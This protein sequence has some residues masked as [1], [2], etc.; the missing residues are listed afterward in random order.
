[1]RTA[2]RFRTVRHATGALRL[3]ALGLALTVAT[4]SLLAQPAAPTS[5]D[6]IYLDSV[7]RA[8]RYPIALRDGRLSGDGAR[9]LS[10]ATRNAQ[11]VVLGESH[12]VAEI[13]RY[14]AALFSSLR[15]SVGFQH[16][17]VEN[18]PVIGSMLSAPGVRGR[19]DASFALARRYPRALQFWDDEEIDAISRI[20]AL[21]AARTDPVWGLD[22]EWGALHVLE[23]L[24]VLAPTPAAR[25]V[26]SALAD[27]AR[28]LESSRP[29][30]VADLPRFIASADSASF[31]RLRRAFR[32]TPHSEAERLIT[33]LVVSNA[34]YRDNAGANAGLPTGYRANAVR[35]L[36]MKE[37]FMKQYRAAVRGGEPL[38]HV[39]VKIGSVHGG[40]WLSSNSTLALGDFLHEFAIANGRES[41][42]LVAW[43]V[44]EPG[45][46]WSITDDPAFR[47]LGR[48]G[49]TKES[50]IVDLRPLRDLW[51]AGRLRA[52]DREM[53]KWMFGYDA[54]LLIGG[55][56][57][58]TYERL[59]QAAVAAP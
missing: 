5:R 59:R 21:S 30:A 7:L 53:V 45:N 3:A 26:A 55:G 58:G 35:E 12:Y 29:F 47:A 50:V 28:L 32:P 4:P 14:A 25:A 24:A 11:F 51:Y 22:Q 10:E 13:P 52:L 31:E 8:H 6:T 56:T 36:Y 2:S 15:A 44:N 9:F 46:Y 19:R 41:F 57:R 48:A 33:S 54:V 39:L 40:K 17:A 38:P 43:P 18:G 23:R 42:H 1:M 27:S 49:S 16:Y 34:I 20:G 37:Q